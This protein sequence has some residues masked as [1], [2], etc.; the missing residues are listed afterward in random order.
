MATPA[1][2]KAIPI[3][4]PS[5]LHIPPTPSPAPSTASV[6]SSAAPAPIA[7]PRSPSPSLL[8]A[9]DINAAPPFRSHSRTNSSTDVRRS[10]SR[11][12]SFTRGSGHKG[13]GSTSSN[14]SDSSDNGSHT[15][16]LTPASRPGSADLFPESNGEKDDISRGRDPSPSRNEPTVTP[17]DGGNVTVLGGGT[18]LGGS[19][20]SSVMSN[21]RTR[22]P[23]VSIA[24]RALGNAVGP[25][26]NGG[27]PPSSPRKPRTRRRIIPTHIGYF[28]QP[29]VG[30]PVMGAF[31]AGGAALKHGPPY[32]WPHGQPGA[33]GGVGVGLAPP[34]VGGIGIANQMGMAH[35]MSKRM[36]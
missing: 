33:A 19:R 4:A 13:Q 34:P 31:G 10:H 7:A 29:G 30:A 27:A 3:R 8:P 12:A 28:G 26:S 22:S 18:K 15:Q 21:H 25:N 2:S 23:S 16:L 14:S 17:Y 24:S 20:P 5:L 35:A 9:A 1:R 11:N 32:Q 36:V 6:A